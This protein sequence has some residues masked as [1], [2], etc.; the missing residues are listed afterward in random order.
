MIERKDDK[1]ECQIH[2][3]A[4]TDAPLLVGFRFELQKCFEQ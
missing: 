4:E 3:A 2:V 1:L